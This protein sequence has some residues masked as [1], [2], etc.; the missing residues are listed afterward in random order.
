MAEMKSNLNWG[1]FSSIS[2]PCLSDEPLHGYKPLLSVL[3]SLHQ[4]LPQLMRGLQWRERQRFFSWF[5]LVGDVNRVWDFQL[6]FRLKRLERTN[7]MQAVN[8]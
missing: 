3:S 7:S 5:L 6:V 8:H 2:N 4:G 1:N